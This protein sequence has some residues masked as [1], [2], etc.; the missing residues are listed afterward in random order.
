MTLEVAGARDEDLHSPRERTCPASHAAEVVHAASCTDSA[1]ATTLALELGAA[2]PARREG[3]PSVPD[4]RPARRRP[5]PRSRRVNV[6]QP[7]QA[8]AVDQRSGVRSCGAWAPLRESRDALK[9]VLT[10]CSRR[11]RFE[12]TDA[13]DDRILRRLTAEPD[14]R[15]ARECPGTIGQYEVEANPLAVLATPV[16]ERDGDGRALLGPERYHWPA[17]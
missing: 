4:A 6:C 2:R 17:A 16:G 9:S 10:I 3:I 1:L 12:G 14:G 13:Q 8:V 5:V 15:G 11:R 7:A